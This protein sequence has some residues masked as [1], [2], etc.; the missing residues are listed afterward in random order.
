MD[1]YFKAHTNHGT[2]PVVNISWKPCGT[3]LQVE[4]LKPGGKEY[5][6]QGEYKLIKGEMK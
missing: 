4:V 1:P 5:L 2:Y 6:R 3:I